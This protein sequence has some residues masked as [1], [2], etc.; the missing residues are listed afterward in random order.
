MIF[1]SLTF[2]FVFLPIVLFVYFIPLQKM[3]HRNTFLLFAS[4]VFYAVGE[5]LHIFIM[6]LSI[7]LN[8]RFGLL[9]DKMETE[10]QLTQKKKILFFAIL[11]NLSLLFLFKYE[12]FVVANINQLTPLSLESRNFMLPIGISFYTFQAISYVIDV[13]RGT[14]PAQKSLMKLG[15][16]IAFFPQLIAGPVI[17]YSTVNEQIDDRKMTLEGF[18]SG[19]QLFII[20][21]GK[22]IVFANNFSVVS[23][24]AFQTPSQEL[25]MAMAWLGVICYSFQIFFDFSGYSDMAIGLAK[26]FGFTFPKNFNYP[27]I[28]NTVSEF[29]RRWHIS[30][31]SWFRDYVY[32]PMGGS[33]VATKERMVFNLLIVWLCTGIWHGSSFQFLIWGFL[34]FC[35]LATEKLLDIEKKLKRSSVVVRF[36]YR[37]FALLF[38]HFAWVIFATPDLIQAFDYMLAMVGFYTT[39]ELPFVDSMA[40]FYFLELKYL[41]LFALLAS[42]PFFVWCDKQIKNGFSEKQ[43][44]FYDVCKSCGLMMIFMISVSYLTI[45]AHNPFIYFNF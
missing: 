41:L 9:I 21:V 22:K 34:Y 19:S 39:P 4:L 38:L 25:S 12:G 27:Y 5:P 36:L 35:I 3:S 24:Y 26:M 28:A 2:L 43:I 10:R 14:V 17:R 40:I 8:F 45:G 15:L 18:Y 16:Y 31:G 23:E 37:I 6:L 30:L 29:W 42:T 44:V 20:G 7:C 1:S 33:R 32:V 11:S 13:Y